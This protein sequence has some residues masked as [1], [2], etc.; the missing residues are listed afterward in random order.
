MNCIDRIH[1]KKFTPLISHSPVIPCYPAYYFT[2]NESAYS[3]YLKAMQWIDEE[4][5]KIEV[6]WVKTKNFYAG[7]LFMDSGEVIVYYLK[8]N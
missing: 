2:S 5:D 7:N 1:K 6:I 4:Q 8:K 3:I